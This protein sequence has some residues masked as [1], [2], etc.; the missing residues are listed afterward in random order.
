M[1]ELAMYSLPG[2][3]PVASATA[4]DEFLGRAPA[5]QKLRQQW[6]GRL[7]GKVLSLGR[8]G[9]VELWSSA[10]LPY[11]T[12]TQR[13]TRTEGDRLAQTYEAAGLRELIASDDYQ[14]TLTLVENAVRAK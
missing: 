9:T 7:G 4:L 5:L 12:T 2:E 14:Q 8:R 3:L 11:L 1:S 10:W 13:W 6:R